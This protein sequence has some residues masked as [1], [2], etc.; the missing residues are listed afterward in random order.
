MAEPT[1]Q[2]RGKNAEQ[3]QMANA[4]TRGFDTLFLWHYRA[5]LI[6]VLDGDT[7]VCLCDT[8]FYGRHEVHIRLAG[9]SAPERRQLG[10]TAATLQLTEILQ[11]AVGDWPLRIVTLQRETIVSE[12]RSFERF[13]ANIFVAQ[14]DGMLRSVA[15]LLREAGAVEGGT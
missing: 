15:E 9:F 6:E 2:K 13:V 4:F 3:P 1:K 12:V 11:T 14:S 5:K 7:I 8:G 10:G